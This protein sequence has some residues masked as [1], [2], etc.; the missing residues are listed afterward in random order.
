MFRPAGPVHVAKVVENNQANYTDKGKASN[1]ELSR[2][3][4]P[5]GFYNQF[6]ADNMKEFWPNSKSETKCSTFLPYLTKSLGQKVFNDIFP[7]GEQKAHNLDDSFKSN[8]NLQQ[9]IGNGDTDLER[10]ESAANQAQEL[11]NVGYLVITAL[12]AASD[13]HVSAIGPQSLT[14]G[15]YP[16]KAWDGHTNPGPAQS[17]NGYGTVLRNYPVFVQAG[18]YTGVVTPGY[19]QG[20]S[21]LNENK[22]LYFLYKPME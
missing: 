21:N 5:D 20:R 4:V 10:A 1:E 8:L 22:V 6:T 16:S 18:A 13:G 9:I 17:G 14:Y 12:D 7:N 15:T 2:F 3:K 19:A 11:A